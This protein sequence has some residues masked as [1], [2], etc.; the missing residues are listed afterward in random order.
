MGPS[1]VLTMVPRTPTNIPTSRSV[2]NQP[3]SVL[4]LEIGDVYLRSPGCCN[5]VTELR[6]IAWSQKYLSQFRSVFW[7]NLVPR[8]R[9]HRG[10]H[11]CLRLVPDCSKKITPFCA[12]S[13]T[14]PRPSFGRP[15]D[16]SVDLRGITFCFSLD[17]QIT[18]CHIPPVSSASI[19]WPTI[20][21]TKFD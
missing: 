11:R 16:R 21:V 14:V 4:P 1:K 20:H 17:R 12:S 2:H 7:F 15:L 3:K 5:F 9:L 8:P 19:G 10:N 13:Q 18:W 6:R